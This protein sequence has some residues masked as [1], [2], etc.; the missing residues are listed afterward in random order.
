MC[1]DGNQALGGWVEARLGE[2]CVWEALLLFGG[3]L[4]LSLLEDDLSEERALGGVIVCLEFMPGV[5]SKVVDDSG[6]FFLLGGPPDF[7]ERGEG[8]DKRG[9]ERWDSMKS[10]G[11]RLGDGFND[12]SGVV[13]LLLDCR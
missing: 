4:V 6:D 13:T 11:W 8:G 7:A 5:F 9:K 10:V 2:V 1:V 3:E 12:V